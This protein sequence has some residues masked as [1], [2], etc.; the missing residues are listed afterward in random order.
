M[1]DKEKYWEEDEI[2]L[3]ELWEVLVKRKKLIWGI[4]F[5]VVIIAVVV[6]FLLPKVYEIRASVMPKEIFSLN[7]QPTI[8]PDVLSKLFSEKYYLAQV[9]P[10]DKMPDKIEAKTK[11]GSNIV[12]IVYD[13]GTPKEDKERIKKLLEVVNIDGVILRNKKKALEKAKESINTSNVA[14]N[15]KLSYYK[16]KYSIID[17]KLKEILNQKE[18][19]EKQLTSLLDGINRVNLNPIKLYSYGESIRILEERNTFLSNKY[20]YYLS[21][22]TEVENTITDIEKSLK[23]NKYNFS[24]IEKDLKD[25]KLFNVLVQ[26]Y[27]IDQPVGPKKKL[28]VGVAGVGSLFFAIFLAFF[29]EFLERG[30]KTHIHND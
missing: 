23:L 18:L 29:L 20:T 10:E 26:P 11:K 5:G 2:D 16:Q 27:Y 8:S 22:K 7:G 3:Y 30:K 12:E 4:F 28:I 19:I 14:L 21:K 6:S 13:T 9:F 1:E 17:N 15:E 24:L 25:L